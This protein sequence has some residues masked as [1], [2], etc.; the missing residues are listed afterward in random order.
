MV[1]IHVFEGSTVYQIQLSLVLTFPMVEIHVFEGSTVYQ[2]QLST[3]FHNIPRYFPKQR[4]ISF[5]QHI[6][7]VFYKVST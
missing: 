6:Y 5:L 1:E 7:L 3:D 2:I 4:S